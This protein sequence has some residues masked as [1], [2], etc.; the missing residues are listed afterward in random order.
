M[1]IKRSLLIKQIDGDIGW[2]GNIDDNASIDFL[3]IEDVKNAKRYSFEEIKSVLNDLF[4][5]FGDEEFKSEEDFKDFISSNYE[6]IDSDTMKSVDLK[7]L[8]E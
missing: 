8:F 2:V 5:Q 3:E 1:E 4:E 7:K 6:I